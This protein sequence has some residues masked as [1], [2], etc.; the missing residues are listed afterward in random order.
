MTATGSFTGRQA[1]ADSVPGRSPSTAPSGNGL[2]AARARIGFVALSP[3]AEPLPSTRIAVLNMLP[4]L[5]RHGFEAAIV[6]SPAVP[7]ET[8]ALPAALLGDILAQ[9]CD[10][11]VFQKMRGPDVLALTMA[12]EARGVRTVYQ[13]CDLVDTPMA[14]ATS[15][16]IVVTDFLR[17]LYPAALQAR[18]HVVH[19]GIEHPHH[20]L[21]PITESNPARTSLLHAVLVTSAELEHLPVIGLPPPWL[22]VTIVARY[23]PR[24]DRMARLRTGRWSLAR[25]RGWRDKLDFLRFAGHPR[26]VREAWDAEGVYRHLLAADVGIIPVETRREHDA[27]LSEVPGWMV[28]SENRLTMKMAVGLPV[29]ATPI[30]A[31]LPVI[32]QGR[33]GFLASTRGEWLD[34]LQ[35]LRDPE[36]RREIGLAARASVISRYSKEA[37]AERMA[38]LFNALLVPHGS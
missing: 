36:R 23:P 10:I 20:M 1:T 37:Q 15:A 12:L 7:T 4:L 34:C 17:S 11:V 30:P 8:P 35:R 24:S 2:S 32:D 6:H 29:V 26:I 38:N 28:K 18:I 5:R 27:P 33:N 19:D 3:A 14:E 13:V 22:R 9:R 16:T 21:R 31:Y 25:R